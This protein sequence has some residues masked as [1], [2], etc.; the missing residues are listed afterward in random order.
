MN[1][2]TIIGNICSLLAMGSDS[3]SATRKTARGVLWMQTLSQLF[4]LI[5]TIVEGEE[6]I[7]II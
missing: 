4:Y 3:I 1:T 5:G 2:A 6:K 7:E